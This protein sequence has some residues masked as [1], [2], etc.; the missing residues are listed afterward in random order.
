M[1]Q[2]KEKNGDKNG[3]KKEIWTQI[4]RKN[5]NKKKQVEEANLKQP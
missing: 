4:N 1:I 3:N 5:S 2:K